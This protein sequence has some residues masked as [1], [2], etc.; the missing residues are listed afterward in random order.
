MAELRDRGKKLDQQ[1]VKTEAI[2]S[3]DRD[4]E[5]WHEYQ[6]DMDTLRTQRDELAEACYGLLARL[7]SH[8]NVH[9]KTV[10]S[11]DIDAIRA[12]LAKVQS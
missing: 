6:H 9:C 3:T 4:S 10:L 1:Y 2:M 5:R 8:Q 12:A 11:E 7:A